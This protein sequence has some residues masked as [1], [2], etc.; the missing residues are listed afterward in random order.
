MRFDYLTEDFETTLVP[1]F[2]EIM[3]SI[4]FN[5]VL[6]LSAAMFLFFPYRELFTFIQGHKI[7]LI[8]VVT[9]IG[10]L[11]INGYLAVRTG[12]GEVFSKDYFSQVARAKAVTME[13]QSDFITY[14]LLSFILHTLLLMFVSLPLLVTAAA[15]S[16]VTVETFFKAL[17]IIFSASILVRLFCFL[18]YLIL[19]KTSS[20]GYVVTRGF[21][22]FFII[23]TWFYASAI[24]P[25]KLIFDLHLDKKP[26]ATSSITAYSLYLLSVSLAGLF[27]ILT[28]QTVIG[29]K[30][31]KRLKMETRK[32]SSDR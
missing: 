11:Y 31:K 21:Y 23:S 4:T 32:L 28:I 5:A 7:P 13:E 18:I 17:L 10:S 3:L 6:I 2:S 14:G 15:I 29:I 22:G 1:F 16:A 27:L 30:A 12:R 19:G 26:L 20:I 9:F 24:N 25:G 8:F